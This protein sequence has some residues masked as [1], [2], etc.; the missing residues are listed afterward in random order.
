MKLWWQCQ[1]PRVRF[2][3][4]SQAAAGRGERQRSVIRF[5]FSLQDAATAAQR[6]ISIVTD[7]AAVSLPWVT[8]TDERL[9]SQVNYCDSL[10]LILAVCDATG[11]GSAG[12]FIIV[13]D[14]DRSL[15]CT[16]QY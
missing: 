13:Y 9:T 10:P 15:L 16:Y 14:N 11:D 8:G 1:A 12:V 5:V 3:G 7:A 4:A 2:G 6:I